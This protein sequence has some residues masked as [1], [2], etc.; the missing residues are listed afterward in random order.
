[1]TDCSD[2][3]HLVQAVMPVYKASE[4][5]DQA[6]SFKVINALTVCS[7][8]QYST[9]WRT[10]LTVQLT[11]AVWTSRTETLPVSR[12]SFPLSEINRLLA[13]LWQTSWSILPE[14]WKTS[15]S[16][17]PELFQTSCRFCPSYGRH[18]GRFCP[19]YELWQTSWTILPELWQTSWSTLPELWQTS[20][21]IDSAL[22][23]SYGRHPGRFC[24]SYEL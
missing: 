8:V 10:C 24:P 12:G 18:P 11:R 16:I 22:V 4:S 17:L 1:M 5:Q 6:L 21:S 13:D 19:S 14:L 2:Q 3:V 23:M 9:V 15:W 20:W 7:S